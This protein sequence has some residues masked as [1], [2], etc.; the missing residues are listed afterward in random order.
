MDKQNKISKKKSI[1]ISC[2]GTGGHFL[3]GL[4]FAK[5]WKKSYGS[6]KMVLGGRNI[7]HFIEKAS[8]EGIPTVSINQGGYPKHFLYYPF[9]IIKILYTTLLSYFFL[10]REKPDVVL[11]MGSFV[12]FPICLVSII[13]GIPLFLHEGNSVVGLSNRILSKWA[14][15]LFLSFP[16]VN[17]EDVKCQSLVAGFPIREEFYQI[18][19]KP[20]KYCQDALK[21]YGL[22]KDFF[23]LF[24]FGGSQ[25]ATKLNRIF[26]ETIQL[27]D[28]SDK[29]QFI[30]ITG[31]N[32]EKIK[33]TLSD[34]P[35]PHYIAN[36]ED[37]IGLC[38]SIADFII[39]RSGASTLSEI[40][41][42]GKTAL[43]VP[44]PYASE[45]HQTHNARIF[46]EGT[47]SMFIQ[48]N[49]LNPQKLCEQIKERLAKFKEDRTKSD[50]SRFL[51]KNTCKI[52]L[53]E[54]YSIK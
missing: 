51:S 5:E 54:I 10:K 11:G 44:F 23:T 35:H 21:K 36:Y 4:I 28:V 42:F 45:D 40:D 47:G 17:P 32:A 6:A 25:G 9:F 46:C 3:P 1:V 24:I 53:K 39:C 18:A 43:F 52:I 14:K 20:E 48:E 13:C 8:K 37:E 26:L 30:L 19:E 41:V 29:I 22:K 38:Y 27:L 34:L 16:V 50:K 12:S 15:K 2:G 31:K 33:L 7:L 49:S